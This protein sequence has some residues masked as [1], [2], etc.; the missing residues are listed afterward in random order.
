MV[1]FQRETAKEFE[2]TDRIQLRVDEI[3]KVG[4][5]GMLM[6]NRMQRS[7]WFFYLFSTLTVYSTDRSWKTDGMEVGGE[8]I[9]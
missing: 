3:A 1:L 9:Y 8:D 4:F 7:K 5:D 6:L 2:E